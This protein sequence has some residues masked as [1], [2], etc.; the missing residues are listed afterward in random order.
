MRE[1]AMSW[2][3]ANVCIR[4]NNSLHIAA[5]VHINRLNR[6]R[7]LFRTGKCVPVLNKVTVSQTI[8]LRHPYGYSC[9]TFKG[10]LYSTVHTINI[11]ACSK[12]FYI[13]CCVLANKTVKL[14][15]AAGNSSL[16]MFTKLMKVR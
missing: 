11:L 7:V 14:C 8:H 16:S 9:E 6:N 10:I 13:L 5:Y 4:Y 12:A 3:K 2:C 1:N 15:S